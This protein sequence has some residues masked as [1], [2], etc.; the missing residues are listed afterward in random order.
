M[1]TSGGTVKPPWGPKEEKLSEKHDELC[2]AAGRTVN[3][4]WGPKE[5]KLHEKHDELCAAAEAA[6]QQAAEVKTNQDQS[7]ELRLAARTKSAMTALAL[8]KWDLQG[9]GSV[10]RADFT[11]NLRQLGVSSE[12]KE[13]AALF[14]QLAEDAG[15][16][17]IGLVELRSALQK[18][19]DEANAAA[20]HRYQVVAVATQ[21][22]KEASFSQHAC[23]IMGDYELAVRQLEQ[24]REEQPLKFK[25]GDAIKGINAADLVSRWRKGTETK[26]GINKV[27]FRQRVRELVPKAN[28]KECDQLFVSLDNDPSGGGMLEPRELKSALTQ[29]QKRAAG[30]RAGMAEIAAELERKRVC[31]VAAREVLAEMFLTSEQD[32]AGETKLEEFQRAQPLEIR[33][34]LLLLREKKNLRG[35]DLMKAW[36]GSGGGVVNKRSFVRSVRKMGLVAVDD[37]VSSI[38]CSSNTIIHSLLTAMA[39]KKSNPTNNNP[40]QPAPY[41]CTL[42]IALVRHHTHAARS[43]SALGRHVVTLPLLAHRL[44]PNA[45]MAFC[46]L[47]A[48]PAAPC[49]SQLGAMFD[50]F[51]DDHSGELELPELKSVLAKIQ[52]KAAIAHDRLSALQ[53]HAS[54]LRKRRAS[55]DFQ[56]A[57]KERQRMLSGVSNSERGEAWLLRDAAT[58]VSSDVGSRSAAPT[59]GSSKSLMPHTNGPLKGNTRRFSAPPA[60][61]SSLT[62]PCV[63][64]SLNG[65]AAATTDQPAAA[66]TAVEDTQGDAQDDAKLSRH[67]KPHKLLTE[68]VADVGHRGSGLAGKERCTVPGV[69]RRQSTAP[70]SAFVTERPPRQSRASHGPARSS[71]EPASQAYQL[72]PRS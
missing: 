3:A 2:S 22:R 65:N 17:M 5:E 9:T 20:E 34:G 10:S 72:P 26:P 15:A 49:P 30:G 14:D 39:P 42:H 8:K 43:L 19:Q 70:K 4:P 45:S 60:A 41:Y 40:P 50:R 6:E 28:F 27:Q 44:P 46:A 59:E 35:A 52:D 37:E 32:A 67:S 23:A 11:T 61:F 31:A 66:D 55:V 12:D 53:K 13:I 71:D 29:L 18:L 7:L 54:Q 24:V 36:E 48:P 1:T 69:L 16:G 25:L 64:A 68:P 33:L 56:A 51:D 62:T 47:H 21:L 58:V 38:F 63:N 57:L